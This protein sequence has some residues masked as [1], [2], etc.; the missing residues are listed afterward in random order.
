MKQSIIV[1]SSQYGTTKRYADHLSES[2]GIEALNVKELKDLS[3]YARVIYLGALYAGS[4]LGLKKMA[5]KM[6]PEQ[7]LFVVTVGL[8]DPADAENILRIR[9]SIQQVVPA[10]S[11][12]ESRL[13]HLRGAIDYKHMG[14]KHRMMMA[15]VH[16]KLSKMPLES[17]NAEER[18]IC[19][20]YGQTVDFVDFNALEPIIRSLR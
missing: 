2:T 7:E 19:E 13:L 9:Q 12:D 15:V 8:V 4:V 10:R 17:L 11:Y 18:I 5:A 16:A 20:T 1:Y 6:S 14:L 3:S